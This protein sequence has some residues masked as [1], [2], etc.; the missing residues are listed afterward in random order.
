VSDDDTLPYATPTNPQNPN[1][2][3]QIFGVI[4]RTVGLLVGLYGLYMLLIGVTAVV[5][6]AYE[7]SLTPGMYVVYGV[8][9]VGAGAALLRCDWLLWFAYGR[10]G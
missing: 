7:G 2:S 5:G 4:V 6:L 3:R 1:P 8:F 9:W 10:E